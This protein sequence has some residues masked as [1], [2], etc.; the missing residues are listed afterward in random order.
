[1]QDQWIAQQT[2]ASISGA[3]VLN[4]R[5]LDTIADQYLAGDRQAVSG[6]ARSTTARIALANAIAEKAAARGMSGQQIA[7]KMADYAGLTAASRSVGQRTA[8]LSMAANEAS[9]MINIVRDT[10]QKFARSDF[11]PF[12]QALKAYETNTGAP[13]VKE[14]GAAIN[15]L[16]N[17]YARAISPS[18][19]PTV[20]DKEHARELLAAVDSP[21]QVEGVLKIIGKELEIAKRA[22]ASAREAIREEIT[23]TPS[24][25]PKPAPTQK[26]VRQQAD[27]I[28]NGKR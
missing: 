26:N 14:F 12:N 9:D 27:E 28:L 18:G 25:T 10:S 22:P 4:P 2:K 16:V 20:N 3:G 15:A 7:A 19:V 23:G 13:E 24:P 1:M 17:V 21:A 8:T 11:V 5:T 6:Y